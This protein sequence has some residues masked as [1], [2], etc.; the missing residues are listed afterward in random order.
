MKSTLLQALVLTTVIVS[1]TNGYA[2]SAAT[3]DLVVNP[4]NGLDTGSITS[5]SFSLATDNTSGTLGGTV[6]GTGTFADIDFI[7]SNHTAVTGL[8]LNT[9]TTEAISNFLTLTDY[10][11]STSATVPGSDTL[12]FELTGVTETSFDAVT[13]SGSFSL[14]GILTDSQGQ[15]SATPTSIT[16][17]YSG[18]NSY[19]FTMGVVATPEPSSCVLGLVAL[20]VFGGLGWARRRMSA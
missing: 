3:G 19:S 17:G 18:A 14:T 8:T 7:V 1:G 15:I 16:V 11:P 13:N 5:S 4:Y 20:A 10:D 6:P 2:Q 12:A 9:P